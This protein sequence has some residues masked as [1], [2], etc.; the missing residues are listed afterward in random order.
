MAI[1]IPSISEII[2]SERNTITN[3]EWQLLHI[4]Q[5]LSDEYTVYFQPHINYAHPDIVVTHPRK[6]ILLIEVKDWNLPAYRFHAH[7]THGYWTVLG[8]DTRLTSPFEQVEGYK[9]ELYDLLSPEL[10][11]KNIYQKELPRHPYSI[12]QNAVFFSTSSY[13]QVCALYAGTNMIQGHR[14]QQ[15][16]KVW[17]CDDTNDIVRQ[18]DQWTPHESYDDALHQALTALFSRSEEEREQDQPFILSKEQRVLAE[19]RPNLTGKWRGTRV[20]GIAGSGKTFVIAQ[21]AINCYEGTKKPVLILTYNITLCHYIRDKIARNTRGW[22][23][24]KRENAF[25]IIHFDRLIPSLMNTAGLASPIWVEDN[26]EKCWDTY[27]DE[28]MS[29]LRK[30]RHLV[31]HYATILIDEAQDYQYEWIQFLQDVMLEK[32]GEMLICADEKQ[33]VFDRPLD[34]NDKLPRTPRITGRWRVLKESHRM[35]P[36]IA[37]LALD[38]QKAFMQQYTIDEYSEPIQQYLQYLFGE[39]EGEQLYCDLSKEP[40]AYE[41]IAHCIDGLI[42]QRGYSPND[43]CIMASNTES[44]REIDFILRQLRGNDSTTSMCE[45]KELY[46]YIVK[47][48]SN[49]WNPSELK[50]ELEDVRRVLKH[51]TFRMNKGTLKLCTI[52]SFKGWEITN[53]ILILTKNDDVDQL[54]YTAITRAKKNL[55][56]INLGNDKYG[57]FFSSHMNKL[58]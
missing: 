20:K 53:A 19:Y 8:E 49:P 28:C 55:L 10:C 42:K 13:A 27:R 11:N 41:K 21:K 29:L 45:S 1:F 26:D 44:L 24:R 43:I 7:K 33:N 3:G 34:P 54:I 47:K 23:T 56:I 35:I 51:N 16:T 17:C 31:D 52:H 38:F 39:F 57:D 58:E 9:N 32:N 46:E 40:H 22:S 30:N 4:L 15:Y 14:Y 50:Q 37:K 36:Q 18:I 12:V 48:H 25:H 6:G 2:T 5:G